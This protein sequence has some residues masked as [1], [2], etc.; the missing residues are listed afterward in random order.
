VLGDLRAFFVHR[1]EIPTLIDF[2]SAAEREDYSQRIIQR[3]GISTGLYSVLNIHRVGIRAPVKFVHEE[4]LK[5]AGESSFWPNQVATVEAIDGSREHIRILVFGHLTRTLRRWC[6]G[7]AP[8]F[9]TLFE[10]EALKFQHVPHSSDFDNARYLLYQ[11]SGG[12]PIGV[13]CIYVRSPIADQGEREETQLFFSVGF[14]FYGKNEGSR[15]W[16]LRPIWEKVHNR[17][18]AN[19]LNRFKQDCEAEF[20]KFLEGREPEWPGDPDS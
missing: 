17:V 19:V 14:N 8:N 20:Q 15:I 5:W 9:G 12:Y 18:T 2:A 3:L 13:F 1:P 4:L 6:R 7:F 11:C 10:M 16:M